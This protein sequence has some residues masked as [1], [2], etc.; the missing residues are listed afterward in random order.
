VKGWFAVRFDIMK[1][2]SRK[3]VTTKPVY[4]DLLSA[5]PDKTNT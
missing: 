5:C 2:N 4:L 1:G 3:T